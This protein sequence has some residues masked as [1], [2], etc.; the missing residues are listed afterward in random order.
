M[1]N[2]S[3]NRISESRTFQYYYNTILKYR[4]AII[5]FLIFTVTLTLLFTLHQ[6]K[7]YE[8]VATIIIERNK[9]LVLDKVQDVYEPMT[10]GWW[11]DQEYLETEYRIIK[12]RN[13]AN[14]VIED[15]NLKNDDR[16]ISKE[17]K[18]KLGDKIDYVKLLLDMIDVELVKDTRMVK[19]KV[20]HTDPEMAAFLANA[21]VDAY[22]KYSLERKTSVTKQAVR[23]LAQQLKDLEIKLKESELALYKFKQKNGILTTSLEARINMTTQKLYKI[24]ED[25]TNAI[26]K[27]IQAEAHLK[28]LKELLSNI[29]SNQII[30]TVVST[31]IIKS[32]KLKYIET[33]ERYISIKNR[34]GKEHP[35]LLSLE[36]KLKNLKQLL[37][38][39]IMNE[40]EKAEAEYKTNK[41]VEDKL[42][43]L[44]AKEKENALYLSRLEIEYNEL[45]REVDNNKRLY[46]IVLQRFKETDLTEGLKSSN[47]SKLDSAKIPKEPVYPKTKLNIAMSIFIG[48]IGGIG[49]A[50]FISYID[51]TI[52]NEE[53]LKMYLGVNNLGII[54]KI[55]EQEKLKGALYKYLMKHPNSM[56]TEAYRNLRTNLLFMSSKRYK[57]I[58]ITSAGP[59]E[60]K[61]TTAENLAFMLTR[62]NER[63]LLVDSDMRRPMI[64]KVFNIDNKLG[65][66]NLLIGQVRI[67]DV[68]K[69]TDV[70][71]LF[72]I[73]CGP[74]P[75]NAAELL[76]FEKTK[77]IVDELKDRFDYVI[78]DSPP[79]GVVSDSLTLGQYVDCVL[80]V[81]MCNTTSRFS[82]ARAV[83]SMRDLNINLLGTVLN[84]LDP[85]KDQGYKYHYYSKYG[86]YYTHEGDST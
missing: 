23:W 62:L 54:P 61:T 42:R 73:T 79:V 80:F 66:S 78:F 59:R 14:I 64:H 28:T 18:E 55:K 84:S 1:E 24:N 65:L 76:A 11:G 21:V 29:D 36:E 74:I 50:F 68:I 48:L 63:V 43:T 47:I 75:P 51:S 85:E 27:R 9:P 22:I 46:D 67:D 52:K 77:E 20:R 31:N 57:N 32:L 8:A 26:T 33:L 53:D 13:V 83:D 41:E 69:K 19:I 81:V 44:L 5:L 16:F 56:V 17:T 25:L 2:I 39:E 10:G 72:V 38:K 34:Y 35:E 30:D 49:L 82:A 71:N 4:W 60:G 12:S 70:E 40:I 7:I 86:Y 58:L 3:L 45:S 15:N 6:K 37:R